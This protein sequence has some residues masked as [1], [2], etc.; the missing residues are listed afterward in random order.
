MTKSAPGK[1]STEGTVFYLAGAT[2][3]GKTDLSMAL[4]QALGTEIIS[5]DS[6]QLYRELAI[7]SAPPSR[8]QRALIPHHQVLNHTVAHPLNAASYAA[9]TRPI[10]NE[11][12]QRCGTA[13]VVG[14]SPLYAKALLAG[15]DPLP[16]AN[17][18]IRQQL[19][20]QLQEEGLP[21][22]VALLQRALP[23]TAAA[24]DLQNP[25][26]VIRALEIF[27]TSG[28]SPE[29]FHGSEQDASPWTIHAFQPV[30]ERKALY[31]RIDRRVEHMMEAGLEEEARNLYPLRHLQALQTVGY[32]ELF[33]YF[34]G[35][36]TLPE[37]VALIQ[38]NTRNFAKRQ[39]TWYRKE[40]NLI[41]LDG[42]RGAEA[43]LKDLLRHVGF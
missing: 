36:L 40:P 34:D 18:V 29:S 22:L 20:Q 9:E 41:A 21:S 26:R 28:Q 19:N 39:L 31:A 15:L 37:A 12:V 11:V 25:R 33:D 1:A 43:M 5:C 13:V 4:A 14:G 3:S 27:Q 7:G 2:A 10:V 38:Q 8:E 32:R 6:R 16:E 17:P 23:E 42:A 30:W 35:V 24:I